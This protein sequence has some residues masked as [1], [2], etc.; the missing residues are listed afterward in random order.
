MRKKAKKANN[1]KKK[2]K[3]EIFE[4]SK[5][6]NVII[7]GASGRDWHNFL[8]YFKNNPCL[9]VVAFTAAQIPGI[10]KRIF[11][12]ELAGPYY[13]ED[14]LIYPE[15]KLPDLIKDLD[16]KH[17]Y[18]SYSDLSFQ[19]VMEKGSLVLAAGANF[20]LLGT[21]ATMI[22]PEVPVVSITAVRTGAGKSQTSRKV[23]IILKEMGCKIAAVRHPMPY[24]DLKKEIVQRFAK[25]DDLKR[26]DVTIEEREEYEPW[27]K[28]GIPV[29]AGVDYREILK[30]VEKEAEIIIWDGGNNDFCF[31]KPDLSIVVVDPLR[32]G[33]EKSYYP[34]LVN[35]MTADIVVINKIDHATRKDVRHVIQNIKKFNPKAR[36]IKANSAVKV[37]NPDMIRE[38]TALLI[39]DGP[40]L[41]HGGMKYGAAKIAAVENR[42]N[43]IDARDYAVGSIKETYEKY[44][45]LEKELPAMGYTKQQIKE[46]EET[47]NKAKCDVVIDGS[48]VNLKRL[49]KS[50]KPIVSVT[51]ELQEIGK[52]DLAALLKKHF[53]G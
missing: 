4:Q 3:K 51:Y 9:K 34:G 23:G 36:I 13:N 26:N 42:V 30:K 5:A 1:S 25:Y 8:M 44:P 2:V 24:G 35:L 16:V 28:L 38:K 7:M 10:E 46:L 22:K 49:I 45:H 43:I 21:G 50:N 48:P 17:V 41:T 39:E 6:D 14:I 33:H 32:A 52:P 40:T 11:P 18:L 31:Y 19:E 27:I 29:Y 12:K 20:S 53:H 37:E 15:E 47:I